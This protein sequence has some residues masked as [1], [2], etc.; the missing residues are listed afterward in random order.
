MPNHSAVPS[1]WSRRTESRL[2]DD[3]PA[4]SIA[5]SMPPA[6]SSATA[7][8]CRAHGDVGQALDTAAAAGVDVADAITRAD[9]RSI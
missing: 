7:S 9:Q 8:S 3:V 6:R 5:I 2:V 4:A 1:G